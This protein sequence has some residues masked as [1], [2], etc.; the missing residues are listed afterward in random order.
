[1][2]LDDGRIGLID[3][4]QVKAIDP[5]QRRTLARIMLALNGHDPNVDPRSTAAAASR[6]ESRWGRLTRR[7]KASG[8][9]PA[10]SPDA[11]LGAGVGDVALVGVAA[12]AARG[13]GPPVDGRAV[14]LR[15][16]TSLA[17]EL[18]VVLKAGAQAEGAAATAMWLF[19]GTV[20]W[21]VYCTEDVRPVWL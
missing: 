13:S 5:E 10:E 21:N 15:V 4:G 6:R 19:D 9:A 8:S 14:D 18:G 20:E 11:G 2:V 12:G 1:M 16:L 3:F 17:Q 7:R